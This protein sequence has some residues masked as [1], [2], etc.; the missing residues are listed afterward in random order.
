ML[1]V[2]WVCAVVP[3]VW[4]MAVGV[5]VSGFWWCCF[6]W[7]V[8]VVWVSRRVPGVPEC[9]GVVAAG[10]WCA[11]VVFAGSWC[12][13]VVV[14]WVGVAGSGVKVFWWFRMLTCLAS[15][16]FLGFVLVLFVW[17]IT[18][19][20]GFGVSG[21]GVLGCVCGVGGGCLVCARVG[22]GFVCVV[23]VVVGLL[24]CSAANG[25]WGWVFARGGGWL[26][27]LLCACGCSCLVCVGVIGLLSLC[28]GRVFGCCARALV[29]FL[30]VRVCE[31]WACLVGVVVWVR[32]VLS[33]VAC[34]L[35]G[36]VM[37]LL[38]VV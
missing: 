29:L 28:V 38:A 4:V 20:L 32:G 14:F 3:P 33:G 5:G 9:L 2:V 18:G 16:F 7:W 8:A 30:F 6:Q 26:V 27:F 37:W 1:L 17:L 21:R 35:L 13:C 15:F 19:C 36:W 10:S 24:V 12:A 25:L 31:C 11:C 34:C 23:G 22:V